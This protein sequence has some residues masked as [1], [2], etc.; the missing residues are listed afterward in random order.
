M[1]SV[2]GTWRQR[3]R[4]L[5]FRFLRRVHRR[6]N[7]AWWSLDQVTVARGVAVGLFCGVLTPV[8]QIAFAIPAAIALRGN[9]L[10][11]ALST[12]LAHPLTLPFA[13]LLAY[14]IGHGLTRPGIGDA[15]DIMISE[16]AIEHSLSVARWPSALIAWASEIALPF[17]LGLAILASLTGL[18][19]YLTVQAVWAIAGAVRRNVP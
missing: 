16:A 10:V 3:A 7:R 1:L 2:S 9:L 8:A 15:E 13:Y 4:A 14:R 11:A 19:G 6:G 5:R 17:F 18:L 12:L